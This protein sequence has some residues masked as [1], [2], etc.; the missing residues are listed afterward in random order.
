MDRNRFIAQATNIGQDT[1]E[2]RT[3]LADK[4]DFIQSEENKIICEHSF[5]DPYYLADYILKN[6]FLPGDLA[7]FRCYQMAFRLS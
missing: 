6:Q 5:A 1:P 2:N 3:C 7:E 4:F